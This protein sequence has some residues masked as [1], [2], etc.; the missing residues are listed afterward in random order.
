MGLDL[1]F[2]C[3]A[4]VVEALLGTPVTITALDQFE[5][6]TGHIVTAEEAIGQHLAPL[7]AGR[8]C[9]IVDPCDLLPHGGQRYYRPDQLDP[10]PDQEATCRPI[11]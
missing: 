6:C 7:V 10:T 11:R 5:D 1:T 3:P 4:A 8:L 2:P 9:V